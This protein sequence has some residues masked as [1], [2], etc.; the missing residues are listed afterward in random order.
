MSINNLNNLNIL[1]NLVNNLY[2]VDNFDDFD[3][4]DNE[5]SYIC[6][7]YS[8]ENSQQH[9]I[10]FMPQ[11]SLGNF[12]DIMILALLQSQL[13]IPQRFLEENMLEHVIQESQNNVNY[14][15]KKNFVIKDKHTLSY[16]YIKAS[17]NT[18]SICYEQFTENDSILKLHCNHI[19]HSHCI[20]ESVKY[21]PSCPECRQTI[22]VYE[23]Q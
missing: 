14:N 15:E 6:Q 11:S 16:P 21:N 17:E 8:L 18:C 20:D 10:N 1:S 4:L 19:F 2:N 13:N 12:Y 9:S 23:S 3:N 5:Y 7:Q 22:E